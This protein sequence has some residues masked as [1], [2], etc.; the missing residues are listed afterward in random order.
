MIKESI[1]KEDMK[2][3]K[4]SASDWRISELVK[5]KHNKNELET[6]LQF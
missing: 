4:I 5:Q 1:Y 3:L 2:I 6:L